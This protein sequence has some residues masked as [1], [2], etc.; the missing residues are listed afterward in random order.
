MELTVSATLIVSFLSFNN[1]A[2]SLTI[3]LTFS[4]GN[5]FAMFPVLTNRTTSWL[6]DENS[7]GSSNRL[8]EDEFPGL[9]REFALGTKAFID[10]P[11]R[12]K[13]TGMSEGGGKRGNDA[14][15]WGRGD[16]RAGRRS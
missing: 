5:S 16:S 9:R 2:T 15:K 10:Y 11:K 7:K 12:R 4:G 6:G 8:N 13:F 3:A 14:K 1:A